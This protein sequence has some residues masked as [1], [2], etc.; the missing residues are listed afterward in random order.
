MFSSLT[1]FRFPLELRAAFDAIEDPLAAAALKPLGPQ[2]M[3]ARGFVSPLGKDAAMHLRIGD[4]L[5]MAV[6]SEERILPAAA[7]NR[8]LRDRIEAHETES[9]RPIGGRERRR[10]KEEVTFEMTARAFAIERRTLVYADLA[11]GL[12]IVDTASRK[13]AEA[14]V[15]DLRTAL[16]SFPATPLQINSFPR[17]IFTQWLAD[18]PA[19]PFSVGEEAELRHVATGGAIIKAQYEDLG[20]EEIKRH[21]EGGKSC[22]KLALG[23]ADKATFVIDEALVLRKFKLT[24]IALAALD[25]TERNSVADELDARLALFAGLAGELTDALFR[26]FNVPLALPLFE[27]RQAA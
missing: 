26:E 7:V 15:S 2:Q 23:Y 3:A 12:L 20:G 13:A 18:A 11:R 24:D 16:G 10:L 19:E 1:F 25:E 8:V 6:G 4:A 17:S 5:L 14:V 21:L 27:L 22:V 9:G